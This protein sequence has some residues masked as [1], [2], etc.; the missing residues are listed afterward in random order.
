MTED[1]GRH[2]SIDKIFRE[3][4]LKDIPTDDRII[5]T[6]GRVSSEILLKVAKRNIPV[7]ISKSAPTDFRVKSANDL[8]VTLIGFVRGRRMNVYT[9]RRR[10]AANGE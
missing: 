6:S 3:W 8:G 4:N 5:I 10:I 2:S 7:I 9:H 1:I